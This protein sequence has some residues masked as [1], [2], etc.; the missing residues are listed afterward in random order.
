[1]AAILWCVGSAL[2]R[3]K[4]DSYTIE[5]EVNPGGSAHVFGALPQRPMGDIDLQGPVG[6]SSLV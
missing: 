2:R 3:L 1:M 5:E 4:E 6:I